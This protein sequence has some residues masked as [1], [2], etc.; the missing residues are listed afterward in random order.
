MPNK[1]NYTY[2][3]IFQKDFALDLLCLPSQIHFLASTLLCA[4]EGWILKDCKNLV[5][6][7]SGSFQLGPANRRY[8]EDTLL[9]SFPYFCPYL[10][11]TL[12]K[13]SFTITPSSLASISCQYLGQYRF[14]A[15]LLISIMENTVKVRS[16]VYYP[17]PLLFSLPFLLPG[18]WLLHSVAT[19]G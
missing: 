14:Q 1:R 12:M 11:E 15:D 9:F 8:M 16:S 10:Q 5:P 18:S 4:L 17:V 7:T 2:N 19:R 3:E 6:L 13:G